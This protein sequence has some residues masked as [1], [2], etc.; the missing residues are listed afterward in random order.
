MRLNI[1]KFLLLSVLLT[2][3]WKKRSGGG[4]GGAYV[5]TADEMSRHLQSKLDP[6]NYCQLMNLDPNTESMDFFTPAVYPAYKREWEDA[7]SSKIEGTLEGDPRLANTML[8]KPDAIKDKDLNSLQCPGYKFA[9]PDERKIFWIFLV[10]SMANAESGFNPQTG[11]REANG[12]TSLGLLQIDV[13]NANAYC[14]GPEAMN[15]RFSTSDMKNPEL[16]L[17]CG[18]H[19]LKQQLNAERP[20]AMRKKGKGNLFYNR[21]YGDASNWS[22]LRADNN[23]KTIARFKAHHQQMPFCKRQSALPKRA[24]IACDDL[25]P[26][27]FQ[28]VKFGQGDRSKNNCQAIN[29]SSFNGKMLM[30]ANASEEDI[31]RN[32]TIDR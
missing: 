30:P 24:S 2:G 20:V 28:Q 3:C 6:A 25:D 18:L 14:S 8:Y 1:I 29:N 15:R 7:W 12:T 27:C 21:S 13:A 11:Y 23:H 10:S 17:E 9:T 4:G 31:I 26:K 5:P 16:N 22:T 32:T 19:I